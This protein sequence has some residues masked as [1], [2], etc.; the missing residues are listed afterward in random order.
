MFGCD[1]GGLARVVRLVDFVVDLLFI[2]YCCVLV[3]YFSIFA[4]WWIGSV[5]FDCLVWVDLDLLG[6]FFWLVFWFGLLVCVGFAWVAL[7][8]VGVLC[9]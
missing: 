1:F 2:V 4:V 3:V 6:W 5:G 7:L 9:Y 8:W